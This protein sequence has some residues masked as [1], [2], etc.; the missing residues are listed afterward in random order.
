MKRRAF[1][2]LLGGAAAWPLGAGAQQA[3]MPV[4]GFLNSL[5]PNYL[6]QLRPTTRKHSSTW[7][8]F[9][10]GLHDAGW[11]VGPQCAHRSSLGPYSI[12]SN[13]AEGAA[14]GNRAESRR[15]L[16]LSRSCLSELETHVC[17]G[18]DLRL[19]DPADALPERIAEVRRLLAGL[20]RNLREY[21]ERAL[22]FGQ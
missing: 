11:C 16:D 5:S 4:I 14:S 17:I 7:Q 21:R 19:I 12:A 8:A 13:I 9:Q 6:A 15:L 3:V 1:I 10:Q 22:A 20:S 2:T 18:L